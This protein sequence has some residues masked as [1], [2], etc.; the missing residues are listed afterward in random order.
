MD[1]REEESLKGDLVV[2]EKGK[3]IGRVKEGG[4]KRKQQLSMELIMFSF[5]E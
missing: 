2:I 1:G 5:L 3:A 4:K